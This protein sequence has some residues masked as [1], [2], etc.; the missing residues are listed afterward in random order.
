MRLNRHR[1]GF[2]L[3]ELVTSLAIMSILMVAMGSAILIATQAWYKPDRPIARIAEAGHVIDQIA[4]ELAYAITVT[5]ASA[6]A[7][8]FTVADRNADAAPE[9]I[10]YAWSG[11]VG[12]PL[13]RKYNGGNV[14]N[15]AEDVQEFNLDYTVL[16]VVP[17]APP[18]S[19]SAETLLTQET[20]EVSPM[21]KSEVTSIKWRGQYFHPND[22]N[23]TPLP[24]DTISWKVTKVEIVIR[25]IVVPNGQ[26]AVQLR[27]ADGSNL[28]VSASLGE[29]VI[30]ESSLPT[31]Y[32]WHTVIFDAPIA[33]LTPTQDLCLIF[34][35]QS[36][37]GEV[38]DLQIQNAPS[39][40]LKTSDSGSTWTYLA[41][42]RLRYKI[43]G[44][45]T[46]PGPPPVSEN[47][48]TSI[49]IR[50]NEGP[51]T[52]TRVETAVQTLNKPV[53]P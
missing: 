18:P 36:G 13:T 39:G 4:A 29:K 49:D 5:E 1:R 16:T 38:A 32:G 22:F 20:T 7:I 44:T 34:K 47:I 31:S 21:T 41:S 6:T 3:V 48:Y 26:V 40:R 28:P 14:V 53:P 45:V 24:A 11:T 50:L 46:T 25:K 19:E 8:T 35:Y 37:S 33:G 10:I 52:T 9:T 30:N 51:D 23:V 42:R 43:H 17:P 27:D 15:V 12:D 2:S